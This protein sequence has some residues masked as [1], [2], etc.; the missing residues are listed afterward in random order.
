MKFLYIIIEKK[1]AYTSKGGKLQKYY[2]LRA[3]AGPLSSLLRGFVFGGK[4]G[5]HKGR[6]AEQSI[7]INIEKT[8]Q[9]AK[10]SRQKREI[11]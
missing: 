2:S 5:T 7:I 3:Q 1:R 8:R 10:W 11:P 4:E 6:D 9:E